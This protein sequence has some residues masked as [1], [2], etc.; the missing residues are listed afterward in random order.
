MRVPRS[1]VVQ[2]IA[3]PPRSLKAAIGLRALVTTGFCPAIDANSATALSSSRE[4]PIALPMPMF[5]LTAAMRGT[6]IGD[7]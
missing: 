2:P 3:T 7:L 1:V 6:A 5:S 4:L